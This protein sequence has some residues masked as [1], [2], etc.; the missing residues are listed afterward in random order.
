MSLPPSPASML[1]DWVAPI[2]SG[3]RVFSVRTMKLS[4][5]AMCAPCSVIVASGGPVSGDVVQI[6]I[7]GTGCGLGSP[8][9]NQ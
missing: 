2:M 1:S 8:K 4:P 6:Q 3:S 9:S 5:P 7:C